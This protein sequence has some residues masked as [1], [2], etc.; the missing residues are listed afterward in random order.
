M[1][2]GVGERLSDRWELMLVDES[3]RKV[4]CPS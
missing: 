3:E 1:R 4:E 2:I